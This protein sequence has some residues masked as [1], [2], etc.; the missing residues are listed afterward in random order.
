MKS[1]EEEKN[2]QNDIVIV[3][4]SSQDDLECNEIEEEA[5]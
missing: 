3:L 2:S 4:N 5:I 1:N